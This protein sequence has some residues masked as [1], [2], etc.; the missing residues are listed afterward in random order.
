M[1]NQ[2]S[3]APAFNYAGTLIYLSIT[4]FCKKRLAPT[5][6]TVMTSKAVMASKTVETVE[7]AA[8]TSKT[9]KTA[10]TMEASEP[11]TNTTKHARI[12]AVRH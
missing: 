9:I 3:S 10:A 4:N 5:T 12:V 7:K 6:V 2:K 11:D 8:G 1:I